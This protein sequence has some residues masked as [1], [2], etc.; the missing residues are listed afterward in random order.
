MI[1]PHK[2]MFLHISVIKINCK[3]QS[4]INWMSV[5]W[6]VIVGHPNFTTI[7]TWC[8]IMSFATKI[9]FDLSNAIK[10]VH[11]QI[12]HLKLKKIDLKN[13]NMQI[14]CN[15]TPTYKLLT[16]YPT[17][18]LLLTQLPT[19]LLLICLP[20]Y[21]QPQFTCIINLQSTYLHA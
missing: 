11:N 16:Y 14:C 4:H 18:Y 19:Y 7:L 8:H 12:C 9:L 1:V 20:T 21:C 17:T 10:R 5:G 2:H 15:E 3:L 6:K 13:N